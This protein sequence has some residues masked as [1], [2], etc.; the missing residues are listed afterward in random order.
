MARRT[1]G[2]MGR[3]QGG[4]ADDAPRP[5]GPVGSGA[6]EH[7]LDRRRPASA[8]GRPTRESTVRTRYP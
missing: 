1:S 8:F 4:R 5:D 7:V 6:T 3:G 2:R